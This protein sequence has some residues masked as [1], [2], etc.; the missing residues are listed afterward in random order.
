MLQYE[1]KKGAKRSEEEEEEKILLWND[2]MYQRIQ[3][4]QFQKQEQQQQQQRQYQYSSFTQPTLYHQ[5][6][7]PNYDHHLY[8]RQQ[9]NPY[10]SDGHYQSQQLSPWGSHVLLIAIQDELC[11]RYFSGEIHL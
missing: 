4:K 8:E 7:I 3:H 6:H 11:S 1:Q 9:Y 5:Q 2:Y 10:A